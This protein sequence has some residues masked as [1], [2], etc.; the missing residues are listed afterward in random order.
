VCVD[1]SRVPAKR[2]YVQN[3]KPE[4]ATRL[5]GQ[6]QE[7]RDLA[8]FRVERGLLLAAAFCPG[9]SVASEL[10][11]YSRVIAR[12]EGLAIDSSKQA[13]QQEKEQ[14]AKIRSYTS[15]L[16]IFD[17]VLRWP[18]GMVDNHNFHRRLLPF[19]LQPERLLQCSEERRSR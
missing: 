11:P 13:D 5:R 9:R 2:N 14:S 3:L 7:F 17:S 18:A 15:S 8:V 19:E 4:L 6:S 1:K 10:L 16:E 12:R